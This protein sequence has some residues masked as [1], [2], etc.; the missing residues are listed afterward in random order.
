MST[1]KFTEGAKTFRLFMIL[2]MVVVVA[3]VTYMI[4]HPGTEHK[5]TMNI[6]NL[7]LAKCREVVVAKGICNVKAE[8]SEAK[9]IGGLTMPSF[10]AV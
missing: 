7:R 4:L 8:I 3:G 5:A 2:I 1:E 6:E 10:F 9:T